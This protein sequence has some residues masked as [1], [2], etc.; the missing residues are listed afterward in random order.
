[1]IVPDAKKKLKRRGKHKREIETHLGKFPLLRPYFYC[2]DCQK[3]FY[4]LD[5]ALGLSA[6]PKQYDVD[7]LG[8]WLASELPYEMAEEDY[9]RCT[10][11]TLSAHRMH[12]CANEIAQDPGRLMF[13]RPGKKLKARSPH[14]RLG[15]CAVR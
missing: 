13:A 5:E 11:A 8:A 15:V 7:D 4:P 9:R 1:M 14:C 3:G 10:G 12:E 6:S 2:V